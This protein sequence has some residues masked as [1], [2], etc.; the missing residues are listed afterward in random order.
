[1]KIQKIRW[2]W[3]ATLLSIVL[4]IGGDAVRNFDQIKVSDKVKASYYESVAV[5]LGIPGSQPEA[6]ATEVVARAPK[7][8]KPAGMIGGAIEV[9]S[10]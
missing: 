5:Y 4:A 1:M 8:E 3:I 10:Q 6:D 9:E 2:Q 7:G